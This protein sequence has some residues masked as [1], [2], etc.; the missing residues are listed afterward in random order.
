ML[1]QIAKEYNLRTII[2]LASDSTN[3]ETLE[4]RRVAEEMGIKRYEFALPGDGTGSI[5]KWAAVL[6]I[7]ANE[8][9][10]P[11]LV[12]CGSG[13]QRSSTAVILYRHLIEGI[14]IRQAYPES[15]QHNH[16]PHK[17]KLLA[18]LADHVGQIERAFRT[19]KPEGKI[20]A[21]TIT[22]YASSFLISKGPE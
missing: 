4:Q 19:D 10:H 11:I 9:E 18:F 5:N 15:F 6:R 7:M 12:H 22:K 17:W 20:P 1:R 16:K 13:A 3:P 8:A 21:D 2:D 14:P